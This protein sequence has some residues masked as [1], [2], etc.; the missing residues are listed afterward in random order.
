MREVFRF[1]GYPPEV[2]AEMVGAERPIQLVAQ[3]H[4]EP[5]FGRVTLHGNLVEQT[6][7]LRDLCADGWWSWLI[8]DVDSPVRGE[9]VAWLTLQ[10]GDRRVLVTRTSLDTYAFCFDVDRSITYLQNEGFLSHGPPLYLKLGIIPEQLPVPLRRLGY[11]VLNLVRKYWGQRRV[12]FPTAPA[13]PSV[14]GWRFIIRS[15][16]EEFTASEPMEF[17]PEGKKYAVTL[18]H[19]IDTDYS[20]RAPEAI[21]AFRSIE[22]KV[23]VRSVWMVVGKHVRGNR[24]ILDDLYGRRVPRP[25]R[26]KG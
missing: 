8:L 14:D 26:R 17:W 19:D 3:P 9:P 21:E 7:P 13:D 4:P 15:L 2:Y 20:L 6:G 10:G 18:S 5:I 25:F 24:A 16:V 22:E 12:L 1:W 23:G 11:E